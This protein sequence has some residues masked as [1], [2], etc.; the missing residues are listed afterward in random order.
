MAGVP[1][2][3]GACCWP[4]LPTRARPH[5]APPP[6][7]P[8]PDSR[9]HIHAPHTCTSQSHPPTP[10]AA[11]PYAGQRPNEVICTYTHRLVGCP[12]HC[13]SHPHMH[14]CTPI[15]IYAPAPT[16]PV[17]PTPHPATAPHTAPLDAQRPPKCP[18]YTRE[19]SPKTP[20]RY[21]HTTSSS[22][23]VASG[24]PIRASPKKP[25][26][27]IHSCMTGCLRG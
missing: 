13:R 17:P 6:L 14:I 16:H 15:C 3:P 18:Q 8:R 12:L 27:F 5:R 20:L 19:G 1:P 2:S 21:F 4:C 11:V 10:P 23:R 24:P 9:P 26:R 7:L 22:C 25:T